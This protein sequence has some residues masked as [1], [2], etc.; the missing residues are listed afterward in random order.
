MSER[1]LGDVL[2]KTLQEQ[3][4]SKWR[5][6]KELCVSWQTVN[7]WAKGVFQPTQSHYE[8]LRNLVEHGV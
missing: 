3:G 2:V 6:A 5:I 1:V 7:L 4:F 8:V